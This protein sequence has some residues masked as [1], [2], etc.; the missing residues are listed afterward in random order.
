MTDPIRVIQAMSLVREE[1]ARWNMVAKDALADA[2]RA[3]SQTIARA[4]RVERDAALAEDRSYELELMV[5]AEQDRSTQVRDR[6]SSVR[7][8]LA[9]RRRSIEEASGLHTA[10]RAAWQEETKLAEAWRSRAANRVARAQA[11]LREAYK[12]LEIAKEQYDIADTNYYNCKRNPNIKNCYQFYSIRDDMKQQVKQME[13]QVDRCKLELR[14]AEVELARAIARV[15]CC[16]AALQSLDQALSVLS[17]ARTELGVAEGE[18][19]RGQAELASLDIALQRA[20]TSAQRHA[21]LTSEMRTAS[22]AAATS[23]DSARQAQRRA[24]DRYQE[25][26][27]TAVGGLSDIETRIGQLKDFERAG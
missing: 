10:T 22:R 15:K 16:G 3:A 14:E 20:Q 1:L 5:I 19:S 12:Q 21:E 4:A 8:V 2:E 7:E 13:A 26:G 25:A 23:A 11:M 27:S 6:L 17:E 18:C 24:D 9:G